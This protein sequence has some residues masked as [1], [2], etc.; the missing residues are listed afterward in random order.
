LLCITLG[1]LSWDVKHNTYRVTANASHFASLSDTLI[2]FFLLTYWRRIML[3]RSLYD[4]AN[5]VGWI[6]LRNYARSCSG[7]GR[8]DIDSSVL[9]S[10]AWDIVHVSVGDHFCANA[11]MRHMHTPF[12]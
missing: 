4:H 10:V 3:Y 2:H 6:R 8:Q 9:L 5:V 7:V 1:T 11:C 12:R